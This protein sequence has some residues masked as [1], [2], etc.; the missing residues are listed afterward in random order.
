MYNWNPR[1]K[2]RMV[3]YL[4]K[5]EQRPLSRIYQ[6][7]ESQHFHYYKCKKILRNKIILI[8]S[9]T[10]NITKALC[11]KEKTRTL[12]YLFSM[13]VDQQLKY[14]IYIH[15]EHT[16]EIQGL[17]VFFASSHAVKVPEFNPVVISKSYRRMEQRENGRQIKGRK[18]L[19][20]E[21]RC[22]LQSHQA[23][24]SPWR[25][26]SR[27][28]AGFLAQ[29]IKYIVEKVDIP[30]SRFYILSGR[31]PYPVIP[32]QYNSPTSHLCI[33]SSDLSLGIPIPPER[34]LWQHH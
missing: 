32:S 18:D 28:V 29:S 2:E 12:C 10:V 20:A 24:T 17:G 15:S 7:T 22:P 34:S 31:C 4:I 5:T 23:Q 19:S 16:Y 1:R 26:W 3:Q 13:Q 33:D 30:D 14:D 8:L 25:I 11:N 9:T 21:W 27:N 6:I